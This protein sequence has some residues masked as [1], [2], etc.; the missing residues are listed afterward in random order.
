MIIMTSAM[1]G[2]RSTPWLQMCLSGVPP[3]GWCIAPHPNQPFGHAWPQMELWRRGPAR[4]GDR[5]PIQ[6]S[7]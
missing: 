3:L 6:D 4:L 7:P 5:E 2:F 1:Y